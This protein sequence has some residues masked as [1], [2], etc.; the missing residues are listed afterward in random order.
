MSRRAE[1]DASVRASVAG[2][3]RTSNLASQLQARFGQQ[4]ESAGELLTVGSEA[5][6]HG[7]V[8]LLVTKA[9]PREAGKPLVDDWD[10][11]RVGDFL[12][13]VF[14]VSVSVSVLDNSCLWQWMRK[15]QAGALLPDTLV[16]NRPP[17]LLFCRWALGAGHGR[18]LGGGLRPARPVRHAP[19]PCLC[20]PVQRRP[21]AG[22]PARCRQGRL[23]PRRC[24]SLRGAARPSMV[25]APGTRG[26]GPQ[27]D[28]AL[29][30][31]GDPRLDPN[32]MH[33]V[34]DCVP[35]TQLCVPVFPSVLLLGPRCSGRG[36]LGA[37]DTQFS[38]L[39][40]SYQLVLVSAV[41]AFSVMYLLAGRTST[42]PP[43]PWNISQVA[44]GAS[45]T[46]HCYSDASRCAPTP[47]PGQGP[48]PP[49]SVSD[50]PALGHSRQR[51][52]LPSLLGPGGLR[53]LQFRP[54]L[55][56]SYKD[57]K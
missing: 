16:P 32:M 14:G 11:L 51:L 3:L 6:S 29:N 37:G 41:H 12:F 15:H 53:A 36:I 21:Q 50:Q 56:I 31:A 39:P 30:P 49:G 54:I 45:P 43:Q 13:A 52:S 1:L 35:A 26:A 5:S 33:D 23:P 46:S 2:L 42:P 9:L 55:A 44:G 40:S 19:H 22:S 38:A 20:Q 48:F 8:E 18:L 4:L 34:P 28:I 10:C 27:V 7:L 47:A 25:L 24:L 57:K 17:L